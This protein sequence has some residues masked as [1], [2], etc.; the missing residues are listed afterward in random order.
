MANH[1]T[2][3]YLFTAMILLLSVTL[4]FAATSYNG[5]N[6]YP[7]TINGNTYWVWVKLSPEELAVYPEWGPNSEEKIPLNANQAVVL[8]KTVV[9]RHSSKHPWWLWSVSLERLGKNWLY[10]VTYN[11]DHVPDDSIMVP[12]LLSGQVAWEDPPVDDAE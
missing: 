4:P 1:R 11:N 2:H 6:G 9:D 7:Q 3:E 10:I 5:H 12:V 8:A